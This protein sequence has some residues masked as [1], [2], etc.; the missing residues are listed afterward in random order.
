M[1]DYTETE[2]EMTDEELLEEID[3][4]LEVIKPAIDGSVL[5]PDMNRIAETKSAC[6][7]LAG[8]IREISDDA[9]IEIVT[10]E[11]THT[12]L[13][14]RAEIFSFIVQDIAEFVKGISAADNFEVVPLTKGMVRLS[15]M[16]YDCYKS[17]G[18]V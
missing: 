16:F 15:V 10:D 5:M 4:L 17:I 8:V 12:A 9:K 18:K 6:S 7:V 14:F 1:S 11:L 2:N 3:A 13:V